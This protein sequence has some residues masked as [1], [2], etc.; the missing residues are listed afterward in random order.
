MATIQDIANEV[1]ISKAA[2]SRI[3]NHKGSFSQETIR[4]VQAAARKLNY[5]SLATF[6]Q[7]AEN[8]LKLLAAIFPTYELPA[9]GYYVSMLE[10]AA[11]DF[12]YNLLLCGSLFDREKED[13][14]FDY[15]RTRK[16]SG[17]ILGSYTFDLNML[18][19]IDLPIVTM[20]YQL[21]DRFPAVRAD[22]YS[23]GR[24]AARHLYGKGCRKPVYITSYPGELSK[25]LRGR[26]FRDE[27]M[28]HG[29]EP[30]EYHADLDMQVSHDFTSLLSMMSLEH[31]DIDGIFAETEVIALSCIQT[32]LSLGFRIPEDI[33]IIGYGASFY[34]QYS[35]PQLTLIRENTEL[36]A[37]KAIS[38]LVA[39]IENESSGSASQ[40]EELLIPVSIW[41]R[42]TT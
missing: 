15:L 14:I 36:I 27:L 18:E 9:F 13:V 34:S 24:L 33:R 10:Q 38:L 30:W 31:P 39:R 26:G 22:D 11:Y 17:I 4:R 40:K 6:R 32:Y 25:D 16:V 41:E 7:E 29:I 20:G 21:S 42:K 12:G 8:S 19:N 3:L 5:S 2:V 28:A 1:G 35:Y 37:R 23:A